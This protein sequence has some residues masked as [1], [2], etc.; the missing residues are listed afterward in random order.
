MH[1]IV[2]PDPSSKD[3]TA[4]QVGNH[5]V[6]EAVDA[7]TAE[8]VVGGAVHEFAHYIYD[9]APAERHLRLI[10]EFVRSAAPSS[11]GLYTYLNEAVAIAA[12]GLHAGKTGDTPDGDDSYR[13]PYIAPLGT[14]TIPL[15]KSAVSRRTTI[16][17]GFA[18]AYIAAGTAALKDKLLEPQ[19]VLAQV[20]LLL[21]DEGD[22][23]RGAYFRNMFPQASAQFRSEVEMDAFPELNMVRFV[24]Y[25]ALG[26]VSERIAGL[27]TLRARRGF[28]YAV[29]RE[30]TAG[31]YIVAGRDDNAIVAA[32]EKM[33]G[34]DS[35]PSEGLI[36]SLD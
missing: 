16:F 13:H 22:A 1:A 12:Q 31:T 15:V 23:I 8:A 35:L 17:D 5:F 33:A 18:P 24:R 9:R 14:A 11:S 10:E 36:L 6:I 3:Y 20:G 34:M 27:D 7:V 21:P 4:T 28:A 30:R 29:R 25:A 26:T 2:G 19:F 32:I